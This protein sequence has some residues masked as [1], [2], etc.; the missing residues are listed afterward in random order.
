MP[1][2]FFRKFAVKRHHISQR[3]F[4]SPFRHVLHNPAYW[5]IRR[6]TVVPGFSMGLFIAFLPF[7][8]HTAIAV[9]L[10][11]ILYVSVPAAVIGSLL[12]NPLTMVP[13]YLLAYRVGVFL[14]GFEAVPFEPELSWA[15][16]TDGFVTVWQPL[17]LGCVLLGAFASLIGF[18]GLD[19]L[20]RASLA[21]YLT[22]RR[23]RKAG[24][25]E[26]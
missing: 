19:L 24:R 17:L 18:I 6:K 25:R 7:P 11:L 16:L 26:D 13:M 9:L 8:A 20:W 1:R 12:S 5:G 14:L 21:E 3:W 4:L 23:Q 2:R 10:A 15:W 22:A